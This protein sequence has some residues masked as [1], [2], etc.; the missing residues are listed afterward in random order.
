M[1][2][3]KGT[4]GSWKLTEIDDDDLSE[5]SDYFITSLDEKTIVACVGPS[6]ES[7]TRQED[8]YNSSLLSAAPELLEALQCII[9]NSDPFH[10]AFEMH[11]N[12]DGEAL[13]ENAQKAI[14]KALGE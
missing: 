5:V 14:A 10:S 11:H 6:D 7:T 3:F 4:K 2:E 9:N 12:I 13:F 8:K 1:G